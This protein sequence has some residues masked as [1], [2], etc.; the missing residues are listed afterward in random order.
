LQASA[1]LLGMNGFILSPLAAI[2]ATWAHSPAVVE[3]NWAGANAGAL[4]LAKRDDVTSRSEVGAQI[5]AD[6]VIAGVAVT[7]YV[8]AAWAH[9]FQRDAGLTASLLGLPGAS[10]AAAGARGE[11]DSAL[12]S[13]GVSAR[14][15]ERVS[16][17]FNL[18]GE[19]SGDSNRLGGSAQ[20]KVSF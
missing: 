16:V 15:S 5:D 10:F 6:T 11:R 19:V 7:G 20:I 4:A 8:R 9:Y 14:I 3:A 17:G 2:Q 12:L 13:A 18:D 1:A